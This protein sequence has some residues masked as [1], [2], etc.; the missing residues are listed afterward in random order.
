MTAQSH[1]GSSMWASCIL[2][3]M[4]LAA[5][6]P[7]IGQDR[8]ASQDVSGDAVQPERA[9]ICF[10]CGEDFASVVPYGH[11]GDHPLCQTCCQKRNAARSEPEPFDLLTTK[12]LTGD[13]WGARTAME[14]AGVTF[15]PLLIANFQQN[16]HGGL[17]T[18][19]A[20]DITGRFFY[21]VQL[22]FGKMGLI[23]NA[24]FFYRAKQEW[25]N[26]IRG[27]VGTTIAPY[28]GSGAPGNHFYNDRYPI[29][30]DK[31]WYRQRF[32]D[33]RVEI[34]VGKLLNVA[35]LF[36]KNA[37]AKTYSKRFMN[38]AFDHNLTVPGAKG[39]GVFA[40][41]WPT[42][43]LYLQAS[44][45]NADSRGTR[46]FDYE[47]VFDGHAHYM[48]NWEF[49]LKPRLHSTKGALP[50]S[51]R[52][53]WWYNPRIRARFR[54][55]LGGQLV[56]NETGSGDVGWYVSFDQMLW[57]ENGDPGDRQGLSAFF[58]Y[59]YAD[60]ELNRL[61]HTWS[62]GAVYVGP[63]PSRDADKVGFAV[64]QSI[65]SN[66]YRQRVDSRADRETVY[67]LFYSIRVTP[68]FEIAPDIQVI[69]N[70]GGSAD[71][72]DAFVAGLRAKIT[73]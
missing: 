30:T 15:S 41:V 63:I 7:V 50:G 12:R 40:K 5:T 36:D 60:G 65:Q 29:L 35:D 51:Y 3:A 55:T 59:G 39:F 22:D 21:N 32:L 23:P 10:A 2:I 72:R 54:N 4:L 6:G 58:R 16:F 69:T 45:I 31:W 57:R 34:R 24:T 9:W 47:R 48:G 62:I 33:N 25:N 61:A 27:D 42:N 18:Q 64:A 26:G 8:M 67:E 71:V 44:A 28:S 68:W 66:Q 11:D 53:G 13:W 46:C 43:W 52:F 19:N 70:P 73:F 1:V 49:G 38:A 56:N 17:N 20:H 37:V 14:D